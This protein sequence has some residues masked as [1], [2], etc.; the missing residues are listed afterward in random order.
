VYPAE[1]NERARAEADIKLMLSDAIQITP[2]VHYIT[3]C[4]T[5]S[6]T[7]YVSVCV[8][9]CVLLVSFTCLHRLYDMVRILLKRD[10]IMQEKMF[11]CEILHRHEILVG[12]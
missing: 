1:V 6:Q 7:E 11:L 2:S 5:H 12:L 9:V 4:F 10:C 8:C 3:R